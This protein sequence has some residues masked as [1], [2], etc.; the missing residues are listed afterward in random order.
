MRGWVRPTA[1]VFLA[2]AT[3]IIVLGN[4]ATGCG[5]SGGSSGRSSTAA[6]IGSG[7][8]V[9]M[10]T[11]QD[12]EV[13]VD[14]STPIYVT[15]DA[16]IAPT[17]LT[18]GALTLVSDLGP[19][20][21]VE[22]LVAPRV[23]ELQPLAS[24][25]PSRRHLLKITAAVTGLLGERLASD[26]L[27]QFTTGLLRVRI[28]TAPV[29][30][31]APGQG[32]YSAGAASIDMTPRTGVPLAGYGAGGRRRG[33]PDLNPF[34]DY[35]FL[36]PSQGARD[37]LMAKALVL[38]NGLEKVAILTLDAIATDERVI[39]EAH[40][41][42]V[43]QGFTVPLENVLV[44]AS[45][46]HSS[47]G[48][49]SK[50]MLWQL[51]AADLY[52][53]AVFQVA[54][55]KIAQVMVQAELGRQPARVGFG[56]ELLTTVTRNRRASDSPV[57]DPDSIDPELVVL[58]VDSVSGAPIATVWN[59][60]IHGTHFGTSNMLFSADIMGSA[61]A[62]A[63]AAGGGGVVMFL[64]GCEGDIAPTG[65]YDPTGQT[66]A[67]TIHRARSATITA[68]MGF[69]GSVS[70]R[71]DFGPPTADWSL[72]RQG[73]SGS[74]GH[75]GFLGA[76]QSIGVGVGVTVALPHGW[77]EQEFR[78]QAIRIGRG[79][80]GSLPGEPIHEIGL[81]LK[82]DGR[83]L[84]FD[85]VMTVGLANGHGAYF[86]TEREY[87]YGGYEALASLFGPQNGTR[88]MD[89]VRRQMTRIRP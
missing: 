28:P 67:D 61:N 34:N 49:L 65:G 81:S 12:G 22:R 45:H 25:D 43:A 37:P 89:S 86:T 2:V 39:E 38:H 83:N 3:S 80:I 44:G 58:R 33:F 20:A 69:L 6:A 87:W 55:D 56:R 79:V 30:P 53:E 8:A 32:A 73:S 74:T 68:P 59:F 18:V 41:K 50:R 60:A 13:D 5:G 76:M 71:V 64:N 27:V 88:L 85:H 31:T 29:N 36:E 75:G 11:P 77:M 15:F 1:G 40:R 82:Q 52:V 16:D 48:C 4:S 7:L 21:T 9:V 17:S 84:G 26:R 63:E 23:V 54:T 51:T 19:V 14:P 24:L 35:T 10:T 42:A 46:S 47:L 57:L 66:I 62:K 70:E 78:I 72:A